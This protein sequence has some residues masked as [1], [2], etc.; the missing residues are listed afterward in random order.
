M[1]TEA[2]QGAH[3]SPNFITLSTQ[4]WDGVLPSLPLPGEGCILSCCK[5]LASNLY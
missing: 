4:P 3:K 5:A 2:G 1:D